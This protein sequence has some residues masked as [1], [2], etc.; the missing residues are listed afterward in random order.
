MYENLS[1]RVRVT[2]RDGIHRR[3][4]WRQSSRRLRALVRIGRWSG[5]AGRRPRRPIAGDG[6]TEWLFP[7]E[8]QRKAI[9]KAVDALMTGVDARISVVH[10]SAVGDSQE[11]SVR[12]CKPKP[13]KIPSADDCRAVVNAA[14][15]LD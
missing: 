5:R 4:D 1:L 13:P 15:V 14:T 9:D 7:G 3:R 10:G 6:T 8:R 11:T 12:G 2:E